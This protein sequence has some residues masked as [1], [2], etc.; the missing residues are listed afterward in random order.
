MAKSSVGMKRAAAR[1]E[2][3]GVRDRIA[4]LN[5]QQLKNFFKGFASEDLTRI[6]KALERVRAEQAAAEVEALEAQIAALVA[7][8]AEAQKK[9]AQA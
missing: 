5:N 8:K 7:L 9:A 1:K 4:A 6:E 2:N 3:R